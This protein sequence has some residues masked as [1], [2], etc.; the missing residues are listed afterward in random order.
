MVINLAGVDTTPKEY[1][2]KEGGYTLKCVDIDMSK[3]TYNGNTILKIIFENK[4]KLRFIEDIVITQNTLFKIKQVSDAFGFTYANVNVNHFIGMYLVA[5][6][7]KTKVKNSAG[8]FVEV[9]KAKK[10]QK[11]AKLQ[12]TIPA[13]G[14]VPVVMSAVSNTSSAIDEIELIEEDYGF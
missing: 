14:A 13:E 8:D 10:F 3:K 11:S 9:L 2:Q 6:L 12:N 7:G 1:I 4:E 5:F